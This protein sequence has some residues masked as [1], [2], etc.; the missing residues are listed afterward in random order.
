MKYKSIIAIL[1]LLFFSIGCLENEN[2]IE[3]ATPTPTATLE[4]LTPTKT[5]IPTPE[6]KA[7]KATPTQAKKKQIVNRVI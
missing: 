5:P 4:T 6:I 7:I 1:I 2:T 3:N